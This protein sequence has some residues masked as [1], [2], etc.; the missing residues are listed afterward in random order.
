MPTSLLSV[1]SPHEAEGHSKL[2]TTYS[3]MVYFVETPGSQV[4]LLN[5]TKTSLLIK[6][7]RGGGGQLSDGLLLCFAMNQ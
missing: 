3:G 7:I 6:A 1:G 2:N 4:N 5:K